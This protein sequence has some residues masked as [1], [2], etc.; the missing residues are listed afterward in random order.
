M[1]TTELII[2]GAANLGTLLSLFLLPRGKVLQH[3]L[4]FLVVSLPTWVIGLMVVE[5][6]LLAYPVRELAAINRTSFCFEYF[7]L[8]I[9]AVHYNAWYPEN[10]RLGGRALYLL[11]YCSALTVPEI[12]IERYTDLLSYLH[13]SWYITFVSEGFIFLYSRAV[14]LWFFRPSSH[15]MS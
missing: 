13:W 5:W 3:H 15:R 8:P 12:L 6:G 7:L 1:Y 14:L 9:V 10:K 11:L 2:L 4:V